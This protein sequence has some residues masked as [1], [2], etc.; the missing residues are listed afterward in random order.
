MLTAQAG[1]A[2]GRD[3]GAA[4]ARTARCSP[5]SRPI[6]APL[7]GGAAGEPTIGGVLSPAISPGPRRVKAGA[8]RDH[9]LGCQAVTGRGE[10]FKAGGRVVKNVTGYDL[11]KLLAGSYG[12]LAVLTEV[13]LK[14]LPAPGRDRDRADPGPGRCDG[15]RGDGRWRCKARTRCRRRPPHAAG[16]CA[17]RC[18]GRGSRAA[19]V[20]ALRLEGFGPSVGTGAGKPARASRRASASS[21]TWTGASRWRSGR[22]VRDVEAVRCRAG[23][24]DL[25]ARRCR[26]RM[27]RGWR[28]RSRRR[29]AG[30][31][32]STTGA[33]GWSGWRSIPPSSAAGPR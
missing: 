7:L 32:C 9:F 16:G 2:A 26:R 23:P 12:T 21:R 13:T 20:T 28:P 8:A 5:S 19:A 31:G 29:L 14:V 18:R 25:A 17:A 10:A 33:A 11:L 1:D 24:A 30:G 4:A 27:A 15:D 6:S 3:R 22:E